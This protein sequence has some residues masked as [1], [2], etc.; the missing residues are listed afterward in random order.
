[1]RS[2]KWTTSH[3][4]FITEIDDQHKEIFEAL[5]NLQ[6][7]LNSRVPLPEICKLT[8]RLTS[9]IVEHFAHE[10]RLMRA[11]RYGSIRWHQQKHDAARRRVE[12]FVLRIEHG[13][14]GAA[15]ELVEYLTSW[16]HDHT[17]LPD[18]MMG[19]F[20][21]NRERCMCR[22]TFRAGTKPK[23]ACVWVDANGDTFDP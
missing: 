1:M 13:D 3:A 12:Q 2:L 10:E 19:A 5:S 20:L 7:L 21:R 14:T 11:A 8:Q 4:V 22:L 17:R 15:F 18:R 6:E 16:L 23:D 9:C